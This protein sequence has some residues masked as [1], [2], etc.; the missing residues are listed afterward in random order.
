M[1]KDI[2]DKLTNRTIANYVIFIKHLNRY[3]ENELTV[4]TAIYKINE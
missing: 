3:E 2:E 1:I 4:I